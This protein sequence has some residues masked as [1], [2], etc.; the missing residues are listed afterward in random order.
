[1][2]YSIIKPPFARNLRDM[3]TAELKSYRAW[4]LEAIPTR[5]RELQGAIISS[6]GFEN[7]QPDGSSASIEALGVWLCDQVET[8]PRTAAEIERIKEKAAFDFGVST[9]ELTDRTF[10]L[11]MDAGMYLGEALRAQFPHLEWHQPRNSKKF[12]DFG[13]MVL[14]GFGQT[15]LNPVRILANFCYG[16]ASGKETGARLAEVYGR[17]F[18]HASENAPRQPSAK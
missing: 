11:A 17:W 10:S 9:K 14:L 7:W 13:H 4:F 1:M 18:S 15:M 12:V 3:S 8:R 2:S 5:I 16:I 6:N